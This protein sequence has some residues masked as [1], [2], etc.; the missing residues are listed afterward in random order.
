MTN[1]ELMI[2]IDPMLEEEQRNGVLEKVQGIIAGAGEL[3]ETAVWGMRKLAYPIAKKADGF[4]AV[5]DFSAEEE[6][7]KELDR[8]L[9]ISD[10]VIRHMIIKKE[11]E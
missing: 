10:D 6:F 3:G 11:D 8:R 5:I 1:Y 2:I 4:Y 9:R 7:P